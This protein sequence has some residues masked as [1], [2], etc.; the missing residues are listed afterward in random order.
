MKRHHMMHPYMRAQNESRVEDKVQNENAE[1]HPEAEMPEDRVD[2]DA[3]GETAP[4]EP[5][6]VEESGKET[7]DADTKKEFEEA[8][9]RMAAEMENYKK[10][11]QREHQEQTRFASEKVLSDLLP[12]LDNLDLALQYAGQNEACKDMAQGIELTRKQLEEALAKHGLTS[13]GAEGEDFDPQI[14]E[15]IGMESRPDI[16]T[17]AVCRIMQKGYKL[18]DRLLRPAKVMVNNY[19]P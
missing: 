12:A 14:H 16:K 13:V 18:N 5:A 9:L 3:G 1:T 2:I 7:A 15:A 17:G 4:A 8:R 10:R 19:Q 6:S 11:L